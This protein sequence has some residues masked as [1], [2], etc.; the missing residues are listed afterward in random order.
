MLA[1]I[2]NRLW[3]PGGRFLPAAGVTDQGPPC[4]Q[5]GSSRARRAGDN[6]DEIMVVADL[7]GVDKEDISIALL[8]PNTLE[9]SCERRSD[10][11]EQD[12]GYYVRERV[13]GTMARTVVLP[14]EVTDKGA[15]ATF[16]TESWRSA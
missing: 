16:K 5:G 3:G 14:H 10:K 8:S 4:D 6:D 13:Y 2:E 1:E 11:E 9:I 15:S 12:E 7:P